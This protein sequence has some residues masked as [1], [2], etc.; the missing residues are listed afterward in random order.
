MRRSLLLLGIS[1]LGSKLF[2]LI[3]DIL[4]AR[5]FGAGNSDP[6]LN[7]DV[8]YAAFRI[9]DA[10]YQLLTA[11]VL[12]AAFI[13]LY[14][15]RFQKNEADGNLFAQRVLA[16]TGYVLTG[17]C[18]VLFIIMP[19]VVG[20]LFPHM[21]LEHRLFTVDVARIL[22]ISP[23]FF[24][25]TSV[26]SGI[27]NVHRAFLGYSLAPI[28]YNGAAIAGVI[29]FHDSL[30]IAGVA[31]SIIV[32]AVL[33][34]LIQLPEV[35]INGFTFVRGVKLWGNDI[36]ELIRLSI[37][38]ILTLSIQQVA[39]VLEAVFATALPIGSLT[40]STYATNIQYVPIGIIGL[41]ASVASF[42]ELS[43][44][45]AAGN[46]EAFR[47][48]IQSRLTMMIFILLPVTIISWLMRYE[49]VSLLFER[50]AFTHDHVISTGNVLGVLALGM[51][52]T[53]CVLFMSR[54]FFALKNTHTPLRISIVSVVMYLA[55]AIT[56]IYLLEIKSAMSLGY[57]VVIMNIFSMMLF[58]V[59]L[60]K[61]LSHDPLDLKEL[62]KALVATVIAFA[63]AMI[64]RNNWP[65][66]SSKI[67][68]IGELTIVTIGA[69][70]S[71]FI[72]L[73]ITGSRY[74]KK[75]L[76]LKNR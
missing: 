54:C 35:F 36:R 21:Q 11:G 39:L 76:T 75:I 44:M 52:P 25:I 32:G 43:L 70:A 38:R 23:I 67:S 10:I 48:A 41:S 14:A 22:I 17:V 30:G 4:L 56:S 63:I 50:G 37:P 18:L 69:F 19:L 6:T 64:I 60:K 49:I 20:L 71:H 46:M 28:I 53:S 12:S 72:V 13:P 42:G 73:K 24:G 62:S 55:A 9:P 65:I 27:N 40:I 68:L 74:L 47:N 66:E 3:R 31:I 51:I 1:F 15:E 26:I 61:E 34:L 33:Q 59:F 5:Y 58:Y 8:Y 2:G 45:K 29:L 7:L 57:S 16:L